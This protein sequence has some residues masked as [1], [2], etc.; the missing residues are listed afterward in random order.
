M[1]GIKITNIE[2]QK[3]LQFYRFNF[4][5]VSNN[6]FL[7]SYFK[8][9]CNQSCLFQNFQESIKRNRLHLSPASY[10]NL[11][12]SLILYLKQNRASVGFPGGSDGKESTCKAGDPCSIPGS[13][14]SP[15]EGNGY[16]LQYSCLES[17]MDRGAWQATVHVV[18]KSQTRLNN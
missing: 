6:L 10:R 12:K 15:G 17:S 18:A 14:K 13:T 3:L 16:P 7:I 5:G 11:V 9:K 1:Y 2:S 4:K 8:I